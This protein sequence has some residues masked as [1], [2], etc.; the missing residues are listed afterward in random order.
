MREEEETEDQEVLA[1]EVTL[2]LTA[3]TKRKVDTEMDAQAEAESAATVQLET[4][5]PHTNAGVTAEKETGETE[6][7]ESPNPPRSCRSPG[8]GNAKFRLK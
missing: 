1:G 2:A 7:P 6:T 8:E 5:S 4:E 3:G